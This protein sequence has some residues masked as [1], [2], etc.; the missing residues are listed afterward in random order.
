M[1]HSRQLPSALTQLGGI[2]RRA[3]LALFLD[4]DGTLSPLV[5]RPEDA[6]LAPRMRER[7]A[8]LARLCPVAVVSGRDR[9]DLEARVNLA[10]L[11]FAGSHGLDIAGPP[12]SGLALVNGEEALPALARAGVT[13]Q[14]ALAGRR[15]V[16]IEHKRLGI[17][18]HFRQAESLDDPGAVA[19]AIGDVL[20]DEPLLERSAGKQVLELRPRVAWD[21]GRAV[22]WL[23]DRMTPTRTGIYLGDDRT[24]ETA[25]RALRDGDGGIGIHVG[26]DDV[27]TEATLRLDDQSDVG[28]F[29]ESLHAAL[30]SK[31]GPTP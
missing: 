7:M 6:V 18:A 17:A 13:L 26:R 11:I 24:D 15:G 10:G 1:S 30:S 4:F 5:S 19:R 25:F 12:G 28:R 8:R 27:A 2:A 21:K 20:R 16:F 29:L 3:P 31:P 22:R 23:L 14:K 9:V